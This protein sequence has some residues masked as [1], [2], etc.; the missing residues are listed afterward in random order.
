[1]EAKGLAKKAVEDAREEAFATKRVVVEE[2]VVEQRVAYEV[3]VTE[4]E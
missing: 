1:V 2:M 3:G 4:E